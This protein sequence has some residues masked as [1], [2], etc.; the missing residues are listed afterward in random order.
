VF[1]PHYGI[2]AVTSLAGTV[3]LDLRRPDSDTKL[4]IELIQFWPGHAD[5]DSDNIEFGPG[6]FYKH[7]DHISD[8]AVG[9]SGTHV[10]FLVKQEEPYLELYL[11]LVHFVPPPVL[12]TIFRKLDT[13]DVK[14]SSCRH[15]GLDDSLGL[16]AIMDEE[17]QVTTI[18]YV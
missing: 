8:V 2:F 6:C 10:L 5:R 18:S 11:G 1:A 12:H 9:D 14:L 7:P 13:G 3:S 17:R 4:D 16:V 15:I